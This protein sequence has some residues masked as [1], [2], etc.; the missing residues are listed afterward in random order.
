MDDIGPSNV[1]STHYTKHRKPS[2]NIR[3][4]FKNRR[5]RQKF[6]WYPLTL[7]IWAF[8]ENRIAWKSKLSSLR[9]F[10]VFQAILRAFFGFLN[11]VSTKSFKILSWKKLKKNFF[12]NSYFCPK[13]PIF[14]LKSAGIGRKWPIWPILGSKKANFFK[15]ILLQNRPRIEK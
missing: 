11:F 13:F 15:I 4:F 8:F 2:H 5:F 14:L 12:S 10:K 3:I 1:F 6:L 9:G 7:W